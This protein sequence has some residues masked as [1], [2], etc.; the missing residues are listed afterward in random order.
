MKNL[1][2]ILILSFLIVSCKHEPKEINENQN[3]DISKSNNNNLNKKERLINENIQ[4]DIIIGLYCGIEPSKVIKDKFGDDL[5]INGQKVI[6][7]NAEYKYFFDKNNSVSLKLT[8][9]EE[10]GKSYYYEGKY[11][12]ISEDNNKIVL[13]CKLYLEETNANPITWRQFSQ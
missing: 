13:E 5:V 9:L 4:K 11:S 1:L 6:V 7:P 3:N 8:A 10:N 2:T 12:V